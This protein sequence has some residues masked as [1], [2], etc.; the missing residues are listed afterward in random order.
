MRIL[1]LDGAMGTELAR[2][3]WEVSDSLWSARVLL[4][5]PEAIE[6]IHYDYLEAGADC[7]TT[8]SYQISFAGF[9][10]AGKTREATALALT[11]SVRVAKEARTRFVNKSGQK[12]EPLVAASVGP[13]GASLADGSEYHGNYTCDQME[14]LTF[15]LQKMYCLGAA[16]PDIFACETIPSW[17][18][19]EVLLEA[20]HQFPQ[21][22]A[23]FSF[24]CKDGEH[25]AHGERIG[26]C[27]RGLAVEHQV[28][29]IGV[30]CTAPE[31]VDSLIAEIRS[32]TDKPI[33]VYP[34]SGQTWD[35]QT[36]SWRGKS[37]GQ[38][39]DASAVSWFEHGARWIGGCCGSTPEDIRQM[40]AA[41]EKKFP[42]A[43]EK[44][45]A[46]EQ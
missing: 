31:H 10:R 7:L 15:H 34:N 38:S 32:E 3:G 23:W 5:H 40:R 28:A 20:L 36:R 24:A 46:A 33:V 2:R 4:E 42:E 45:A 35:A 14:L 21:F 22:P 41:L 27:A 16:D 12:R 11:E 44:A 9:E 37:S 25:T 17:A 26:D 8:A 30:N 19:A 6:Q 13:Y 39:W 29:A 1:L 43:F 18:E